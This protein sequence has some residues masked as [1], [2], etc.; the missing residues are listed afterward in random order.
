MVETVLV[1]PKES[2]TFKLNNNMIEFSA[3]ARAQKL[4]LENVTSD[5]QPFVIQISSPYFSASPSYGQVAKLTA[6]PIKLSFNRT[7]L[8]QPGLVK[9][10]LYIR[11][12]LGFPMER[13]HFISA[14]NY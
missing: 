1:P 13:Y 4:F 12:R 7:L 6:I 8:K 9:G 10:Y 11:T 5:D 2:L 3:S 14:F